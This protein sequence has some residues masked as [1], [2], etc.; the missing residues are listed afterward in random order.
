MR[1]VRISWD[2]GFLVIK[3]KLPQ[4]RKKAR[5]GFR[6][7]GLGWRVAKWVAIRGHPARS[8]VYWLSRNGIVA[9]C[10]CDAKIGVN[11]GQTTTSIH[12]YLNWL[13]QRAQSLN[14]D[15]AYSPEM[16]K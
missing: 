14:S 12:Q 1:L 9:N 5:P 13:Q 15:C 8:V 6:G 2:V 10:N 7:S 3:D 4:S 11:G 16:F